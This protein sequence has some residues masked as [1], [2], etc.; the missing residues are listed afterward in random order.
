M[1]GFAQDTIHG[2]TALVGDSDVFAGILE[3]G[4]RSLVIAD[5]VF[6]RGTQFLRFMYKQILAEMIG[7]RRVEIVIG[8]PIRNAP[9]LPPARPCARGSLRFQTM[10]HTS[11]P[12]VRQYS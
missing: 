3:I 12:S 11:H 2:G 4:Q 6:M 10:P 7:N 1:P 5:D 8:L 9:P